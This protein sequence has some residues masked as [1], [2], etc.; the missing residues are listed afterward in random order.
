[1]DK[2][3][4]LPGSIWVVVI[5]TLNALAVAIP[6]AYPGMTWVPIAVG[7]VD[8]LLLVAKYLQVRSAAAGVGIT[9]DMPEGAAGAP[10]PV[11]QPS[12]AS[13]FFWG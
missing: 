7:V 12:Q 4:M 2:L 6:Q 10:A 3:P 11:H 1:M 5:A 13:Q 8:V 9:G